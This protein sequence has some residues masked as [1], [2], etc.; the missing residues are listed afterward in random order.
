MVNS[1]NASDLRDPIEDVLQEIE[2]D[3][4]NMPKYIPVGANSEQVLEKGKI[5]AANLR[6]LIEA[7]LEEIEIGGKNVLK[8]I[9]VGADSE[10]FIE[11]E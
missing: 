8:Y 6:D 3:R 2:I 4:K 1:H 9:L 11:M 10:Q 7:A 5:S